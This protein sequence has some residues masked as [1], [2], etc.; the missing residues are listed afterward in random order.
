MTLQGDN[1]PLLFGNLF[2]LGL[3]LSIQALDG[4]M[5]FRALERQGRQLRESRQKV[6]IFRAVMSQLFWPENEETEQLALVRNSLADFTPQKAELT[7][8]GVGKPSTAAAG[9]Y[10][11]M[12]NAGLHQWAAGR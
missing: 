2:N 11:A 3:E 7:R 10:G 5:A 1:P 6:Q 4:P 12:C 9:S 8:Y